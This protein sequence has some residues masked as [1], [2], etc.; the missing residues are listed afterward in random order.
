MN[1][2]SRTARAAIFLAL[3]LPGQALAQSK[4]PSVAFGDLYQ[5]VELGGIF[6]DQKTFADAIPD[7]KPQQIMV[8]YHKAK[9][10]PGFDLRAF[11]T[12]HFKAAPQNAQPIRRQ[13]G[14]S[15]SSYIAAMWDVLSRKPD[16][17]QSY[18]SLLPLHHP[19]VVP[20]GRF[21]EIYY[22]D[23]YFTML[24]LIQDGRRDLAR[25]MLANIADLIAAYGHMPNGNRSYYLSRSQPPYF[26]AMVELIAG[27]DRAEF[28][29]RYLQ[30]L[31]AEYDYWMRGSETLKPGTAFRRAVR[32]KDGT[33]LNRYWDDRAAP[34]DESYREDV[35]TAQA[36]KR[37]ADEIYRELRA[38]SESG[39]DFSSRWFSGDLFT[40]HTTDFAPVDLNTLLQH[41]EAVL[42]R[43]YQARGDAREAQIFAAKAQARAAAIRR[44]MWNE[45]DGLFADYLWRER[46]QSP[47][48]SLAAVYP[49]YFNVAT[50]DQ[51]HKTAATLKEKFLMPGGLIPTLTKTG[52]QWD[53]PNGWAPL[54][55]LAIEGLKAYGEETL[56]A[57]IAR[58]WIEENVGSY[59]ASGLLLEKYDAERLPRPHQMNG[60][61]GGEYALQVGFGWTNGVL[62]RLMAEYPDATRAAEAKYPVH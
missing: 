33:L 59:A 1:R 61:G 46:R 25:D 53:R 22:W 27:Q 44:L 7:A 13:S 54:E 15:V 56:A 6:P 16:P 28:Y 10:Q 36:A 34:R 58:R 45:N 32:L 37:P 17:P 21:S 20:G 41:L 47:V 49:L 51:A 11:V 18:S 55:Y 12:A 31:R 39:W 60:G 48:F 43:A 3:L 30:D 38:A 9:T 19:Y 23:S 40:I 29:R 4:P 57:E 62:K 5:A 8:E 26:S 42:S 35:E 24:G 50:P 2:S 52:E 14:Q